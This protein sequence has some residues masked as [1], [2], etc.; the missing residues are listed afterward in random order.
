MQC[1]IPEITDIYIYN[2]HDFTVSVYQ[3]SGEN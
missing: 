1:M 3:V 2:F